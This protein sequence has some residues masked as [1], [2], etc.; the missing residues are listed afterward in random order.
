MVRSFLT[1]A[2]RHFT[3]HQVFTALSLGGLII[4]I[5]AFMLIFIW[6]VDELTLKPVS[7][8]Q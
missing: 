1:T 4:G 3:R 6:V 8:R 5:S 7:S 2:I